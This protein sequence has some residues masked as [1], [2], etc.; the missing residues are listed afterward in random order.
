MELL[1]H[2]ILPLC[3]AS[4]LANSV[5][6]QTSIHWGIDRAATLEPYLF[7]L[8]LAAGMWF[9]GAATLESSSSSTAEKTNFILSSSQAWWHSTLLLTVPPLMHITSFQRRILSSY[10]SVDEWYDL[11][12]VFSVPYLLN[13]GMNLK[14]S[15]NNSPYGTGPFMNTTLRGTIIPIFLSII[16][17]LSIQQAYLIPW[18]QSIAYQFHGHDL[19]PTWVFSLYLTLATL[20]TLFCV[21]VSGR[22]SAQTSDLLFGEFHEDAIQTTLALTGLCVGKAIGM[23]WNLTPLPILAF[24]GL[25]VW[26]TTRM[27]RTC[28]P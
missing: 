6:M 9:M 16:A 20:S 8:L 14:K 10:A 4:V 2:A 25:S 12:L 17:S 27:V 26:I 23:P 19:P 13:Y 11:V 7:A 28:C 3:S 22:K 15:N 21:W 18:C 5:S 1:L 24:L